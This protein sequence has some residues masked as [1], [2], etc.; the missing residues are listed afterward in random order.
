M[1]QGLQQFYGRLSAPVVAQ[2]NG[3]VFLKVG[4]AS[5]S[6]N[7][8][9]LAEGALDLRCSQESLSCECLP[10]AA[11]RLHTIKYIC[12]NFLKDPSLMQEQVWC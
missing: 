5:T 2:V 7:S 6:L 11:H 10:E 8:P 4:G 1:Q 9:P 12:F 3:M